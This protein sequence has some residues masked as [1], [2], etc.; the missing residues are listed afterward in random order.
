MVAKELS[1]NFYEPGNS[2]RCHKSVWSRYA[3]VLLGISYDTYL[4]YLRVDTSSWM[5][6]RRVEES[7][8]RFIESF[9]EKFRTSSCPKQTFTSDDFVVPQEQPNLDL[10]KKQ[11]KIKKLGL[12]SV[13]G[14]GMRTDKVYCFFTD[15]ILYGIE[16]SLTARVVGKDSEDLSVGPVSTIFGFL[17]AEMPLPR[18]YTLFRDATEDEM[19]K[20]IRAESAHLNVILYRKQG[21]NRPS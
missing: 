5:G 11:T 2:C 1:K 20:F 4:K 8:S 6:D 21:K 12:R 10:I 9:R 13:R 19:V 16:D 17:S 15:G 7:V 3:R 18:K 14:I